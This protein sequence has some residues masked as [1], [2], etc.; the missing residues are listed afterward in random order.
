MRRA[1]ADYFRSI[2]FDRSIIVV[3][4]MALPL[5]VLYALGN[6]SPAPGLIMGVFLCSPSDVPG[7]RRHRS[8]SILITLAIVLV[9]TLLMH[10]SFVSLWVVLPLMSLL[11][12]GNAMVSVYG[13]RASLV[14]FSGLFAVILALARPLEMPALW[15]HLGFMTL[16]GLWYW[17]VTWVAH[18]LMARK[19]NQMILAECMRL[20]ARY[21]RVR[22][23]LVPAPDH[24]LSLQKEL[25]DLQ[26]QL[27]EKHEKLREIFITD[28]EASGSSHFA[29]KYILIFIELVDILEL[30][31]ANP[32]NYE[33]LNA[34]FTGIPADLQP[35]VRIL[36]GMA[37]RLDELAEAVNRQ[38]TIR[39]SPDFT[40]LFEAARGS[41][42]RY[43]AAYETTHSADQVQEG[44]IILRNLL[45]YEQKQHQKI[46][47]I[48]RVLS[49]LIDQEQVRL[50]SKDAEKFIT[51]QDYD[52]QIF[53][54]NLNPQ[55]TIF[56]HSV[57]LTAT[58]LL[59]FALGRWFQIQNAYWIVLTIIVIMRPSYGLTKSR[60]KERVYGT[61]IGCVVAVGVVLLVDNRV[62][63]GVLAG[64][65][66]VIAFS[67][68]QRNYRNSAIFV[69]LNIVFLYVLIQ[70][71]A[72][73]VIQYR[74]LDTALGAGMS[75]LASLLLWPS[76]EA[77]SIRKFILKTL[78]ANRTYLQEI[79]HF[80]QHKA[81]LPTSYKL[82][83]KEAFLAIGDLSAAFQRM[84]QEP[85]SKRQHYAKHYE[86]VVLNH[87]FLTA[88][89]AMGTFIQNH[90]TSEKS[91]HVQAYFDS[92][93][94]RLEAAQAYLERRAPQLAD[95]QR[96]LV[97]ANAYM[98]QRLQEYTQVESQW[99]VAE[100]TSVS[101]QVRHEV[102]EARLMTH[103]LRWMYSLSESMVQTAQALSAGRSDGRDQT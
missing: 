52:P 17:C 63:Y 37:Q 45:D 89:T 103:H 82:A 100:P 18:A 26:S 69:T 34:F 86:M 80:Y 29:E 21:L 12:F 35:F 7:S 36:N 23:Q 60:S 50:R 16:G 91:E 32:A 87:T 79:S 94:N 49:D 58:V 96:Q 72:F 67:L 5:G 38:R 53:R 48:E 8:L 6:F 47:S 43:L 83:R 66:F 13:F 42:A 11:V 56:R 2:D 92:I 3:V 102:Q 81:E 85:K 39:T 71:D 75:F 44:A 95:V 22:A 27:N 74:F 25:L 76:W 33:K 15:P 61:L 101:E 68:L 30:A 19:H 46:E 70:P 77:A 55:S 62:V 93:D 57:R 97:E 64:V 98:E 59:G 14:S 90:I 78:R 88:L 54:Q 99:L 31:M 1:L 9:T 24:A 40:K 10:L 51:T 73:Q 84:N 20:T 4:A 41:I 28:R 65:S